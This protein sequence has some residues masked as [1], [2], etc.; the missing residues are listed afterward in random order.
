[1]T[2]GSV[3][4]HRARYRAMWLRHTAIELCG[5]PVPRGGMRVSA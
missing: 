3:P 2:D 1:M 4:P 5:K